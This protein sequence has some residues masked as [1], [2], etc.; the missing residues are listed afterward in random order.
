MYDAENVAFKFSRLRRHLEPKFKF[1]I[2][3]YDIHKN[4][5]LIGTKGGVAIL[6]KKGIIVNQEWKNEHFNVITDNE[7][8]AL[9]IQLLNG[10]KVILATIY[11]PNGNPSLRLF[12][13]INVL[14]NQV[15]FL[16]DLNSKHKQFGC[17]K[18]NKSG[19]TL[20][21][22]DK[23]LKLCHVNQQGPNRHTRDD[24]FHGK[25]D[26]SDMT[27]LFPGLN[28]RDISISIADDHI[29][30]DHFPIQFSLDP[31]KRN[32]GSTKTRFKTHDPYDSLFRITV[33]ATRAT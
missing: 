2:P 7:A 28:S 26:I 14:S 5:R 21:N 33:R 30:S 13:M 12:R 19:Q 32:T 4:D 31:L 18:P 24:S 17:V 27:F 20:G 1:H 3:G 6:V 9:E 10:E 16:G 25:S 15:I 29:G 11:C 22:I 23:D 8:L